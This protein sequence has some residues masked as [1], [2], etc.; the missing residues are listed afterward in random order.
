MTVLLGDDGEPQ[1]DLYLRVLPEC[2]GQSKTT[3]DDY[4]DGPPELVIEISHA[5]RSLDLHGKK[6]EYARHGVRE[7]IVWTLSD[8]RLHWFD[9]AAGEELSA[10]ADGVMRVRQFPGLWIDAAALLGKDY[11]KLVTTMQQGL[12]T[13]EHATFVER[14][15]RAGAG[16]GGGTSPSA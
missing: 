5:S 10:D 14:L 9:L 7:Y 15:R 6:D 8:N 12:A 2:G 3:P 11:K 16:G 4:V 13:P 1:P